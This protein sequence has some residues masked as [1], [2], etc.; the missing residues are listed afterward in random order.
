[1]SAPK[2]KAGDRLRFEANALVTSNCAGYAL[3]FEGHSMVNGFTEPFLDAHATLIEPAYAPQVGDIVEFAH[4]DDDELGR[5]GEVST[6]W[7]AAIGIYHRGLKTWVHRSKLL[8]VARP[9]DQR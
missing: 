9:E 1:M 4:G 3:M 7:S 8:F 6:D 2:F 5:V